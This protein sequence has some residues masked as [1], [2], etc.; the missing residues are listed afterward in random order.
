VN[1]TIHPVG[2]ES[3]RIDVL[4]FIWGRRACQNIWTCASTRS[5]SRV[6]AFYGV[7]VHQNLPCTSKTLLALLLLKTE[8]STALDERV[9]AGESESL[10]QNGNS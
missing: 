9:I 3:R 1:N 4:S 5:T 8:C 2:D 6:F 10:G 7:V